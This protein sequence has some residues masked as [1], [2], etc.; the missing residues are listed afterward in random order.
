MMENK[1]FTREVDD[2]KN[3]TDG[4]FLR[5][6]A[7]LLVGLVGIIVAF[8]SLTPYW[9]FDS[10]IAFA[11]HM[12]FIFAYM[13]GFAF[14]LSNIQESRKYS[15]F[16]ETD[17]L[18]LDKDKPRTKMDML[19][20]DKKERQNKHDEIK[21][22]DLNNVVVASDGAIYRLHELVNFEKSTFDKKGNLVKVREYKRKS[23]DHPDAVELSYLFLPITFEIP[24][25]ADI[26][27]MIDHDD[28][29]I[30][31]QIYLDECEQISPK[32]TLIELK[33]RM[34]MLSEYRELR[35]KKNLEAIQQSERERIKQATI[36]RDLPYN[37]SLKNFK[38]LTEEEINTTRKNIDNT[39]ERLHK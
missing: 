11:G 26:D 7:L 20:L 35:I 21:F 33:S 28:T 15:I 24:N 13:T 36:N 34:D 25:G 14:L 8:D 32:L 16:T 12:I 31:N 17:M 18:F 2:F 39:L 4:K 29:S 27:K 3:Y 38:D 30:D 6:Y 19:F 23:I 10:F 22:T 9:F 1:T 37:N 5:L